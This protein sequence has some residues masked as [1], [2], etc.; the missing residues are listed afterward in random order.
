MGVQDFD[1]QRVPVVRGKGNVV[2]IAVGVIIGA[3]FGKIVD[4]FVK[5]MIMPII[6]RVFGGSDSRTGSSFSEAAG[7]V[8]GAR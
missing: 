6:G 5:D 2:H 3:A 1:S 7:F 4:S 8:H